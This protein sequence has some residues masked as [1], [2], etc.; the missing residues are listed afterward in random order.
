M[1]E[2]FGGVHNRLMPRATSVAVTRLTP[3]VSHRADGRRVTV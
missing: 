2:G 1:G 3:G